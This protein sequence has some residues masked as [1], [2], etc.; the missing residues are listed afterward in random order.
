MTIIVSELKGRPVLVDS[1]SVSTLFTREHSKR[2]ET[3]IE[4]SSG[5]QSNTANYY[6]RARFVLFIVVI[7][8]YYYRYSKLF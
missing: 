5:Q 8:Y 3:V 4:P 1:T 2:T 7:D 6:P